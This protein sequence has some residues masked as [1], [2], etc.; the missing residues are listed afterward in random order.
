MQS[1]LFST[2]C[3]EVASPKANADAVKTVDNF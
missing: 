3:A 1:D 2:A